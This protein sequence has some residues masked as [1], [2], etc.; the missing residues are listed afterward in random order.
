[1]KQCFLLSATLLVSSLS[2]M[3]AETFYEPFAYEPGMLSGA[4]PWTGEEAPGAVQVMPGS[5]KIDG[6]APSKGSRAKLPSTQSKVH[7]AERPLESSFVSPWFSFILRIDSTQG[8]DAT[9]PFG[10]LRLTRSS[11]Q[12]GP[13]IY[14]KPGPSAEQGFSLV[15]SKRSNPQK[16]VV[17]PNPVATKIPHF[18][19]GHYDTSVTPHVL[20][21]WIDPSADAFAAEEA[22]RATFQT[23]DGNDLADGVDAL[24]IGGGVKSP[25]LLLDEVRVGDSWADVTPQN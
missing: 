18:V 24:V 9:T 14:V 15:I 12:A 1:M 4:G 22:P 21:V 8:L 10:L 2:P 13:G 5:L 25:G 16:C 11:G 23:A 19:V 17:S 3:W 7:S 6:L 20:K